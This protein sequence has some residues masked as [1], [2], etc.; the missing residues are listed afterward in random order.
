MTHLGALVSVIVPT[1]NRA[2]TLPRSVKS[3]F[4]QN[5]SNLEL[6]IVDDGSTDDTRAFLETVTDPRLR[7]IRHEVNRGASAARSTGLA[8]ARGDLIAFQ[9]S[10]D[11]WLE[12][13]LSKQVAALDA[14]GTSCVLVYCTKIVYGRD[15]QFRRGRRRVVC[16]PGPR[17]ETLSGDL[18]ELLW[19]R[20]FIGTPQ[21]LVRAEAARRIGGFDPRIYSSEEWDFAIRLSETGEFEFVDEPLINTYIQTDSIS[22]PSPRSSF[23]LLV[24]YN[25]LKRKGVPRRIL[26][27]HYSK[28]GYRLA[29]TGRAGR[30]GTLIRA[31]I[32][33]SPLAGKNWARHL[34]FLLRRLRGRR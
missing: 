23:G 19:S 29:R 5:Y 14:A 33:M 3:V 22:R 13:K 27:G 7:V 18:R 25:K 20:S 2:R 30:G 32:A 15:D 11:E 21:M 24:I 26:S 6:I 17:E 9:D 34:A 4:S 28:L 31:A 12:G 10:D 1:Y 16:V 8:A